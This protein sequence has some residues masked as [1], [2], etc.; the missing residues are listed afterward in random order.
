MAN[1]GF[2]K[3]DT[4]D[5]IDMNNKHLVIGKANRDMQQNFYDRWQNDPSSVE[6]SMEDIKC[7]L[8][9]QALSFFEPLNFLINYGHF[10]EQIQ[11]WNDK[12]I[13]YLQREGVANNRQAL[14]VVGLP[15]NTP[16]QY[17]SRPEASIA[18]GRELDETDFNAPTA[19]YN[20]LQCLHPLL[21]YWKP[22]GRTMLIKANR[23]GWFPP[24]KDEPLL[25]RTCF[26]VAVFLGNVDHESYEWNM[27]GK[28]VLI[29]PNRA[30][31][32]DTRKTHRTAS[33]AD[34]SIHLIMNI[35]KTWENVI[36]LVSQTRFF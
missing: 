12:W 25:N 27:E 30:Y 19:L 23:G 1:V 5:L 29:K 4:G 16:D 2:V 22:L 9:L 34:D 31:Y 13:P 6:P 36:K 28:N 24:H 8:Q 35:P 14:T 15:G 3:K 10:K 17:V 20:E 11:P 26:R 18:A 32:I 21:N 7:E 33:W